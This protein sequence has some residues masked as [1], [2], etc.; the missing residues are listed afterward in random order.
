MHDLPSADDFL[1]EIEGEGI[2]E[3]EGVNLIKLLQNLSPE[4]KPHKE[5]YV[6]G[7]EQHVGDYFFRGRDPQFLDGETGFDF[8]PLDV[9][10]CWN[11]WPVEGSGNVVHHQV[12]PIG[13]VGDFLNCNEVNF[14]RYLF[15]ALDGDLNDIWAY[16]MKKTALTPLGREL[17]QQMN[18]RSTITK[19]NGEA[20]RLPI[21]GF[22]ANAGRQFKENKQNDWWVPR[23]KIASAYP[24]APDKAQMLAA[25][26]ARRAGIAFPGKGFERQVVL[27]QFHRRSKRTRVVA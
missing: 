17:V 8:L 22:M 13:M 12:K 18:W 15:L 7:A 23:F 26:D 1:D 19:A 9:Q 10:E 16:P 11:E 24:T 14:T 20:R 21:Y 4:V 25:R 6:P 3:S 5:Q 27:Q 2:P